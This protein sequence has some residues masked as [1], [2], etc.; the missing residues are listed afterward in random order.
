[1]P[2]A[3]QKKKKDVRIESGLHKTEG[4]SVCNSRHS[5]IVLIL[6]NVLDNIAGVFKI[7]FFIFI[8][9]F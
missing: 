8:L 2:I 9:S 4:L 6:T 3:Y 1:M 5:I 7:I